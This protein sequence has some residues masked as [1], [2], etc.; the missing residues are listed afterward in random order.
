ML[1]TKK[2]TGVFFFKKQI[3]K[4]DTFHG[5]DEA[6]TRFISINSNLLKTE[7]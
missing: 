3:S 6:C 2:N 5:T 1:R 7:D 4:T